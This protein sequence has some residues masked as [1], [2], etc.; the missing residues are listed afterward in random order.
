MTKPRRRAMRSRIHRLTVTIKYD[1]AV[2]A[3]QARKAGAGALMELHADIDLPTT[4][5]RDGYTIEGRVSRVTHSG[6]IGR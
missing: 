6:R 5:Y 4:I 1:A 3:E 2:S